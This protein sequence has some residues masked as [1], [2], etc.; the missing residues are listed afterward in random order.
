VRWSFAGL[1]V[2]WWIVVFLAGLAGAPGVVMAQKAQ[3]D[4]VGSSGV[5]VSRGGRDESAV[6]EIRR[7]SGPID[8]DGRPDDP[9]WLAID[10]LPLVQYWP[11]PGPQMSQATEIRV[12]YDD[13]Y[14]YAVGRFHDVPGGVRANSFGRD[15]W[16]GD[17]SFDII[18]DSFND[19]E[20]ALKFTVLPLGALLDEEV[21]NDASPGG[22]EWPLNQDWNGFWEAATQRS[23]EGWSAE[24]RIPLSSLG[25]EPE[26]G[27]VVMGLIAGRYIARLNEKHIFPALSPAVEN[28]EFKPS[29]AQDISLTEVE[30]GPPLY[31]TPYLLT[32]VDRTRDPASLAPPQ[33]RRPSEVGVDAKWGLTNNLTLDLTLNTDFAQVESDAL[34]VNLDR[35]N[36]F[37]PEKRQFFQERA[38]IFQF[39]HGEEGRLFHSRRI[40]LSDDGEPLRILG[41]ARL[42]GRV[43]AWDVGLLSMQVEGSAAGGG[44]NDGAFRLRRKV[45][46][47]QSSLG[48]ML[49][50]RV[51]EHGKV[52]AAY[53][54]DSE[55]HLGGNDFFSAQLAQSTGAG[56]GAID[57]SLARIRLER[58][59]AEGL[60][61]DGELVQSGVGYAP[62][63]GFQQRQDFRAVK[64]RLLN[65]WNPV[66]SSFARHR[67]IFA[68]NAYVRNGDNSV[69]SFL[70]RLRYQ[71]NLRGGHFFNA[72]FNFTYEDV[73]ERIDL[74]GGFVDP[75]SYAG[76]NL[77]TNI[78][79]NRAMPVSGYAVVWGGQFMDGWRLNIEAGPTWVVSKH[80]SA[81]ATY[82][83]H[84][85]WFPTRDQRLDVDEASLRLAAALDAKLSAEAFIQ[86][87]MAADRAA[88]N[89]RLRYRFAEGRDLFLVLDE[90]RDVA[91]SAGDRFDIMG[92]SDR[93]LLIKYAHTFRR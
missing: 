22:G 76:A 38:G 92:R 88:A 50:S 70:A 64:L 28:A 39:Q 9:A 71:A 73:R 89:F 80:L 19:N 2:V 23:D 60:A 21:Q 29:L 49:T 77:F 84:R 48:A 27:R 72:A 44:G 81:T 8:F 40:G 34:Q 35:F 14:F 53:G 54:I 82:R 78:W 65:T 42:V 6:M 3:T 15:Q 87:S 63:L 37:F 74:P 86:Y 90:V 83:V 17:D 7:L 91:A 57:R 51:D 47:E 24:V 11:T 4:E 58:R 41:G 25:F 52:E 55:V 32:G 33:A 12:A 18:I 1:G 56:V 62:V 10:P 93:R 13:Q 31:L 66:G 16:D 36:L 79:L 20:T 67:A 85:L 45:L 59:T 30:S 46:N 68:T 26:D 5:G 69:E 61:W 43:G 75:G